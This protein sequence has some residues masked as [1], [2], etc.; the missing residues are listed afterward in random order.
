MKFLIEPVG[1]RRFLSWCRRI[2][3]VMMQM[4]TV[5]DILMYVLFSIRMT[6]ASMFDQHFT[7]LCCA[8]KTE[9]KIL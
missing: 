2:I 3:R 1:R 8:T 4:Q 7:I 5:L 6:D 9:M